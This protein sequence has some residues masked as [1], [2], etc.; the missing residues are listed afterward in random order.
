MDKELKKRLK[1]LPCQYG[2]GFEVKI[3]DKMFP[4]IKIKKGAL[5]HLE[6][7]E[8]KSTTIWFP[9]KY[10]SLF[11]WADKKKKRVQ[12][13]FTSPAPI[14]KRWIPLYH[15]KKDKDNELEIID[16]RDYNGSEIFNRT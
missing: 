1:K 11:I 2:F 3:I 14:G 5:Y 10:N 4:I 13:S 9:S 16:W 15:I 7:H 8:I 6:K 12:Y